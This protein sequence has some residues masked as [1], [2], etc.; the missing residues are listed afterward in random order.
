[1]KK[2]LRSATALAA[3]MVAAPVAAHATDG[4]YGRADV[5][6]SLDGGLDITA[7][8]ESA[9][10]ANTLNG[11]AEL[12]EDWN[13]H[14]GLGYA[15]ASGWRLEGEIGHRFNDLEPHGLGLP[16]TDPSLSSGDVQVWSAML[17]G[18]FDMNKGHTFQPYIGL[19]VGAA[20]VNA[21]ATSS[22]QHFDDKD[23]RIAY[24]AM[25]GTAISLGSQLA[26]DIGYRYFTVPDLDFKG[27]GSLGA[28]RS[29]E[30]DYDQHAATIGLRW[31][32]ASPPPPPAPPPPPPPEVVAPVVQVCPAQDFKVYFEWDRS[33]LNAAAV[34]TINAAAAR[35]KQCNVSTVRVVGYTDTSGSP[36][37]NIGLSNR[38]AAVVRD[39]LVAAGIPASL[40]A[41][42]GLGE[43]NLDKAT[44]DGVREPLNRRTAVTISFQ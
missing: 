14:L 16:T 29:F 3:V 40:V 22:L 44:A 20:Q 36:K 23:T 13:E 41:T 37:Y 42:E 6:Y 28:A 43:T 1:M 7:P 24:Q 33:N 30:A 12:N 27:T 11:T 9:S 26:L 38:R 17:N 25:I 34:D 31:Q 15:F 8:L 19:G 39:A 18:Y 4:W 10:V 5:G 35:A 21:N 32:F 2:V